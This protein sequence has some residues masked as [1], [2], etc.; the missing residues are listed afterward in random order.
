MPE[1]EETDGQNNWEHSAAA[2][3]TRQQVDFFDRQQELLRKLTKIQ[4]P[5]DHF[6]IFLEYFLPLDFAEVTD[7]NNGY[8][9]FSALGV[10]GLTLEEPLSIPEK[11]DLIRLN[12]LEPKDFI[13][14]D[15]S[16]D[17]R[18]VWLA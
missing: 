9:D 2:R 16:S 18:D 11:G 17:S 14:P 13:P 15:D 12:R 5:E 1:K 7:C 3:R 8:D 6:S 4:N 10:D